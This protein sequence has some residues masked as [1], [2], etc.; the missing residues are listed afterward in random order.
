M[1]IKI[2]FL[3]GAIRDHGLWTANQTILKNIDK[4]SA[5]RFS[6]RMVMDTGESFVNIQSGNDIYLVHKK[7]VAEVWISEE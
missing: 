7:D 6:E 2:T 5:K 1:N 4:E 3:T